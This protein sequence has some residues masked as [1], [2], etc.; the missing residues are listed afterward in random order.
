MI[1]RPLQGLGL[2]MVMGTIFVLGGVLRH[3]RFRLEGAPIARN[4]KA[5]A[6]TPEQ[7]E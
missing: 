2:A 7:E 4:K 1:G 5:R 6:V 3:A